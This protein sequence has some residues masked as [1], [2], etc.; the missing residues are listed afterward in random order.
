MNKK[1]KGKAKSKP[2]IQNKE[3]QK[4]MD[5]LNTFIDSKR[6]LRDERGKLM[7]VLHKAQTLFGYI[8]KESI[9]LISDRLQVP[10]AHIYGMV[11]F[12][13]YFSL[14]LMPVFLA[15]LRKSYHI[16]FRKRPGI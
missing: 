11:T 12:Y 5:A 14:K 10:T 1:V 8:P 15:L 2:A 6:T 9:E 13:N 4:N 3:F 7:G 16:F